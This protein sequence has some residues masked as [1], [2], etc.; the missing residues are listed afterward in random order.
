MNICFAGLV[1]VIF[2]LSKAYS[3]QSVI[4]NSATGSVKDVVH[5][6]QNSYEMLEVI[7][8]PR[9]DKILHLIL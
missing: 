2:E 8:G 3:R 7:K 1:D 6:S 9:S 4:I 5:H